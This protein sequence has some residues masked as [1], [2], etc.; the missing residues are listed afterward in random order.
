MM[1]HSTQKCR[2][3]RLNGRAPSRTNELPTQSGEAWPSYQA[4]RPP[5]RLCNGC[6]AAAGMGSRVMKVTLIGAYYAPAVGGI[7][8][9][10]ALLAE[11]L[12]RRGL[13]VDV[14]CLALLP[15]GASLKPGLDL[16][17]G[18]PVRRI[19]SSS[20]GSIQLPRAP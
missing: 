1:R 10:M 18:I 4:C 13:A 11:G 2:G 15:S 12:T 5:I 3:R 20:F 8:N 6:E 9:H 7:E 14:T 17:D 16:V 19:A